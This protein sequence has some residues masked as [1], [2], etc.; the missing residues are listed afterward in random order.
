MYWKKY[1]KKLTKQ[2]IAKKNQQKRRN[3]IYKFH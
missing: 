1:F 2:T 3:E